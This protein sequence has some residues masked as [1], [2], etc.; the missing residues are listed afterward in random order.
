MA[1]VG[2]PRRLEPWHYLGLDISFRPLPE[3]EKGHIFPNVIF[4]WP[5][6][7]ILNVNGQI[8]AVSKHGLKIPVAKKWNI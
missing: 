5:R 6:L 4:S 2:C 1:G 8:C 7:N 3:S